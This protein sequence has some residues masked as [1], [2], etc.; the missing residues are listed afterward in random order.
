MRFAVKLDEP[1][2]QWCTWGVGGPCDKFMLTDDPEAVIFTYRQSLKLGVPVRVIGEGSN[3]LVSDEGL[4]GLVIAYR[5]GQIEQ[6][7]KKSDGNM[8]LNASVPLKKLLAYTAEHGL[9]GLE[10]AAGIPGTLAGAAAGNAGAG[11]LS[12]GELI[13]G[14]QVL[15][16]KGDVHNLGASDISFGYRYSSL[17]EFIILKIDIELSI[18]SRKYIIENIKKF[19]DLRREQ[20]KGVMTAGC[21]FRNPEGDSAGR[22]LDMCGCKGLSAGNA[23]VSRRHANFIVNGG[24]ASAEDIKYLTKLC[25]LRVLRKTGIGL[26]CEVRTLG[27]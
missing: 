20:P 17:S 5:G 19:A 9:S 25:A 6:V 13:T 21:V 10:F 2:R 23:F 4:R 24:G 3:I 16:K 26:E 12:I 7:E 11:G 22:L 18:S 14:A 8:T 15:D 27:L 1:L